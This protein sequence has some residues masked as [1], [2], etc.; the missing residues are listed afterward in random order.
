[1]GKAMMNRGIAIQPVAMDRSDREDIHVYL[2]TAG[3]GIAKV[4]GYSRT[5]RVREESIEL[6][7]KMLMLRLRQILL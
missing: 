2:Y 4:R 6:T 3:K 7:V 1:M 5:R